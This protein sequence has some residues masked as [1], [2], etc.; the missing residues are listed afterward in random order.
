VKTRL[1]DY[2]LD[3]SNIDAV[4]KHLESHRMVALGEQRDVT[5]DVSRK[6][7]ELSI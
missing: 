3:A 1:A 7:L 5:L 6:V 2:Q 4:L